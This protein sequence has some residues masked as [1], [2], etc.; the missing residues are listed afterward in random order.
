MSSV[1][2]ISK[3]EPIELEKIS[4]KGEKGNEFTLIETVIEIPIY[5]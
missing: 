2:A 1:I 4:R 3:K 5:N